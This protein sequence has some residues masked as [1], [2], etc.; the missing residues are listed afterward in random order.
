LIS[1][2]VS[3]DFAAGSALWVGGNAGEAPTVKQSTFEDSKWGVYVTTSDIRIGTT[4]SSDADT[5]RGNT[6]A[7][8]LA[9]GSNAKP[10]VR[11]NSIDSNKY[12][13]W[14]QSGA[15]PDLGSSATGNGNN[16]I[17]NSTTYCIW[18]RNAGGTPQVKAEGNYFGACSGGL[19]PTCWSG[20]VLVTN[21][22]CSAPFGV[23]IDV[24]AVPDARLQVTRLGA[25]PNPMP[26]SG[27]IS[28]EVAEGRITA[29]VRIY[30]VAGRLV[31]D[32]GEHE[33]G[34]GTHSITWDGHTD[35]GAHARSGVYFVRLT[36]PGV[37]PV[38]SKLVMAR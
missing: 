15:A 16:K 1:G 32:L 17:T 24:V 8:I 38:V 26:G 36:L 10:L 31:R 30:D 13:V 25:R 23:D 12:G 21:Y 29:R 19:P 33:V 35:N 28:F 14:V 4:S 2:T 5:I 7:G 6:T 37:D 18:N 27:A 3:S 20:N 9:T 34:I 11:Y 22:Q